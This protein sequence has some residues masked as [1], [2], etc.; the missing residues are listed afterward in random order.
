MRRLDMPWVQDREAS[1]SNGSVSEPRRPC[2]V[3]SVFSN[4][5]NL[6]AIS[7]LLTPSSST[8]KSSQGHRFQITLA[9]AYGSSRRFWAWGIR[10]HCKHT[11][12]YTLNPTAQNAIPKPK[13][14]TPYSKARSPTPPRALHY[15]P[16]PS[17]PNPKSRTTRTSTLHDKV[18][19]H[20]AASPAIRG[21]SAGPWGR[22]ERRII[23]AYA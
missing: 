8:L 15:I 14:P 23:Y 16:K 1:V 5:M 9:S 10:G 4:F 2:S 18:D 21:S 11:K 6:R 3:C 13:S 17:V 7:V 20:R 22:V 19:L 12:L